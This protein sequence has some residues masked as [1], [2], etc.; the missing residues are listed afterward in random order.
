M[1]FHRAIVV[2]LFVRVCT[3]F[4]CL[5]ITDENG[6][7]LAFDDSGRRII[8]K[9]IE[10]AFVDIIPP[11]PIGFG[12]DKDTGIDKD[13]ESFDYW[14]VDLSPRTYTFSYN[15]PTVR[16][17]IIIIK[18]WA[19]IRNNKPFEIYG[20]IK[21][22][23]SDDK[24]KFIYNQ[25][26]AMY[27]TIEITGAAEGRDILVAFTI[28][29]DNMKENSDIKTKID[30]YLTS[31]GAPLKININVD[32]VTV[33]GTEKYRIRDQRYMNFIDVAEDDLFYNAVYEMWKHG[34]IDGNE[35]D[36]FSPNDIFAPH[37]PLKRDMTVVL[38]YKMAGSPHFSP[39]KLSFL[40][41]EYDSRISYEIIWVAQRSIMMGYN[42][43]VFGKNDNI[44]REQLATALIRYID[45]ACRN[46]RIK[47]DNLQIEETGVTSESF[48]D[49]DKISLYAKEPVERALKYGIITGKTDTIFDPQGSVTRAEAAVMFAR[50]L[51]IMDDNKGTV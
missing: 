10:D 24:V 30:V 45:Y 31:E 50:V 1:C 47:I 27:N 19:G 6:Y 48:T 41:V 34:L 13:A 49:H 43:Y 18:K 39:N 21:G 2:H 38:L 36:Y 12:T 23:H 28:E 17:K 42:Q 8:K 22:I 51:Q 15:D 25:E 46:F 40:D 14:C 33:E 4:S 16:E 7:V 32:T 9:T 44:S 37:D 26:K 35:R 20:E 3:T 11:M 29:T 5:T